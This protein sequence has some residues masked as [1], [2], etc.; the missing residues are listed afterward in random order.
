MI[1]KIMFNRNALLTCSG[2]VCL[3]SSSLANAGAAP[4]HPSPPRPLGS[5]GEWATDLDYPERAMH[6]GATGSVVFELSI[7]ATG[8]PAGCT[9]IGSSNNDDLDKKT[10]VLLMQ[11]ARFAPATDASGK[12]MAA[13][14]RNL[15]HWH[16]PDGRPPM[17]PP[18]V[19]SI[20]Y[21]VMPDGTAAN[22]TVTLTGAMLVKLLANPQSYCAGLG[23]FAPPVDMVGKHIKKHVVAQNS[24]VITNAP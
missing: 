16:I 5:P 11:R 17:P 23:P 4:E 7:S 6:I 15:I 10:C 3:I 9:V 12:P 24:V 1:K 2:V 22:C 21:D 18:S 19:F 20:E 8:N 14:Y 13:P